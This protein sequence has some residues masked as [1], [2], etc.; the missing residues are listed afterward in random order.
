MEH[1]SGIAL[2]D[3]IQFVLGCQCNSD[4]T[5]HILPPIFSDQNKLDP[6]PPC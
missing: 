2:H 3:Y 4:A 6:P 5:K 1:D